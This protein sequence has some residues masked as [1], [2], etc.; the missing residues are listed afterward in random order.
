MRRALF[1]FFLFAVTEGA[2]RADDDAP[3][4]VTHEY[5][6]YEKETIV[7]ALAETQRE[8]EPAPEGKIVEG[9]DVVTLEVF[10]K[11]DPI[12]RFLNV[13]H[14]TSRHYAIERELLLKPGQPYSQV[15]VDET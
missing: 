5:S 6:P 12:P 9:V 13:F 1:A 2:A 8:I 3:I 11:R 10:E 14:Y 15:V 4:S 7:N